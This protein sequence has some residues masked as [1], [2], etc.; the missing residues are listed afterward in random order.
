[1]NL[2]NNAGET[3]KIEFDYGILNECMLEIN[4][5]DQKTNAPS[6]TFQTGYELLR[7]QT[8]GRALLLKQPFE[9]ID[10]PRP[11]ASA[12][13]YELEKKLER[14]QKYFLFC[15]NIS[16]AAFIDMERSLIYTVKELFFADEILEWIA[17]Y[18]IPAVNLP[19]ATGIKT[20][21]KRQFLINRLQ[22]QERQRF[23]NIKTSRIEIGRGF[24]PDYCLRALL[25]AVR[26]GLTEATWRR[27]DENYKKKGL[28][29]KIK[30]IFNSPLNQ[31]NFTLPSDD[32]WFHIDEG[33]DVLDLE[34]R[35]SL[36]KSIL[37]E[38]PGSE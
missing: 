19:P 21:E 35:I 20:D 7:S 26:Y 38:K 17:R 11:V 2:Q 1:M 27:F 22:Q 18:S 15:G 28:I 14:W 13:R 33:L 10:F 3:R 6:G 8:A 25:I 16:P 30:N 34:Y 24:N 23:E 36:R 12:Q 4:E 5:R 9:N 32:T 31:V 29:R 37:S